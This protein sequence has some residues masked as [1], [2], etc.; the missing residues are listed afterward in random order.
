MS[1]T[2]SA[3]MGAACLTLGSLNA[4][5]LVTGPELGSDTWSA[6]RPD[7]HAPIGVMGDHTH[8]KGEWMLSYRYMFMH[9]DQTFDGDSQVSDLRAQG[10]GP[11]RFMVVPTEMDMNMHMVGVMH[12]VSD[13]LTLLGMM[14]Y[15]ELSME[16]RFGM[17]GAGTFNTK[18]SGWGDFKLGG[19][20]KFYD[21]DRQRAHFGLNLVLPTG[22]FEEEDATPASPNGAVLPYPMQLGAGTWGINPSLTYLAQWN[23]WSMGA[24]VSGMWYFEDNDAGWHP[25]V[26][27]SATSWVAWKWSDQFSSS[28]R[29]GVH[30]WSDI[31]GS[32]SRLNVN[33]VPTARTDLRAGTRADLSLGLNYQLPGS[34][35]RVGAEFGMP[36]YQHLNGPQLGTDYW[37]TIGTQFSW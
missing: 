31:Q 21:Q 6:S 26:S 2:K 37:F 35:I 23:N 27:G 22:D 36:V 17:G 13:N 24:Q 10:M 19:L 33:M 34:G 32:D 16:H 3:M 28:L 12:A 1:L 29:L 15:T 20:Y 18:T 7:S 8:L 25:G 14:N 30:S 9:M 11:G 4:G 5:E